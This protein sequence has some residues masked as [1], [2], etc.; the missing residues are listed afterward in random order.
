MWVTS[1][2]ELMMLSFR[3]QKASSENGS[4]VKKLPE[5]YAEHSLAARDTYIHGVPTG[6]FFFRFQFLQVSLP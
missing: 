5:A 2:S 1:C 3:G 4:Q 6:P